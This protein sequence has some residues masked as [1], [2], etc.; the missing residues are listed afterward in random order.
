MNRQDVFDYI[1]VGAGPA[2]CALAGRLSAKAGARVLL[3]E[4]GGSAGNPLHRIP[5]AALL[6]MA[7][8]RFNWNYQT[9]PVA[10]LGGRRLPWLAGRVLGGGSTI[11]GMIFL[12]GNRVDFDRWRD[13]AGCPGWGFDDVLPY[14]RRFE[15]SERGAGLWHGDDGPIRTSRSGRTVELADLFLE[16]ASQ[17]GLPVVDDLNADIKEGVG[18]FDYMIGNGRRSMPAMSY[19]EPGLRQGNLTV[20]TGA[21]VLKITLERGVARGV[22]FLHRGNLRAV[23]ADQEIILTAGAI[24]SAQLLMLSGIGPADHLRSLGIGVEADSPEVG[25]NLQ[26]HVSYFMDYSC[27]APVSAYRYMHPVRGPAALLRYALRHSGVL[28]NGP[29]PVGG[30]LRLGPNAEAADTQLI[31]GAGLPAINRKGFLRSLPA[32]HGFRFMLNQGR[33]ASRGSIRLA[34]NSSL[35]QPR[36]QPGYLDEPMD[37]EILRRGIEK[38]RDIAAAP[39][40]AK[41]IEAELQPGNEIR[42]AEAL[43]N[44]IRRSA[45]N[46]YHPA[47]TCRMGSDPDSVVDTSLR[48]RGVER[49]RIADSSVI[50]LLINGNTSATALMLGERAAALMLGEEPL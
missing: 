29:C 23:G 36:I 40:L 19:L 7:N 30:L 47:G 42:G 48:V 21:H 37:I 5:A 1:I 25:R 22:S 10:A 16:A 3:L 26:N 14:F 9:E 28:A 24:N 32:R 12:R 15:R 34:S 35:D 43:T 17:T 46:H 50:P 20:L 41:V 27:N 4:A 39:A 33:P 18:Y 31:L 49:L 11:N 6:T 38:C 8:A 45:S 44:S 2:G 13:E